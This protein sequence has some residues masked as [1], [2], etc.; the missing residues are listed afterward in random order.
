MA[1]LWHQY[2][3][4]MASVWHQ[5]GI[6]LGKTK[7]VWG[8]T[9]GL[10]YDYTTIILHALWSKLHRTIIEAS[11]KEGGGGNLLPAWEIAGLRPR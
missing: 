1:T 11:P 3:I 10:Y 5:Y 7:E 6:S 4:S 8:I 9:V 2:G